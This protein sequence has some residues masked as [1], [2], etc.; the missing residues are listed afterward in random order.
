M[1]ATI[2]GSQKGVEEP[3][4][5]VDYTKHGFL[6]GA[7]RVFLEFI[8]AKFVRAFGAIQIGKGVTWSILLFCHQEK[9][10]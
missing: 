9:L 4:N 10:F 3:C 5:A 7:R 8:G 6:V 2:S 1:Q